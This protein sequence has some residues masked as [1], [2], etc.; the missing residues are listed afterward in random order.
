MFT[1][2]NALR[3]ATHPKVM[4]LTLDPTLT[5]S[6][7]IRNISIQAHKPLQLI[8][9]LTATG[10]GKQNETLLATYK[11][12]KR[13][14]LE[15]VSS[16]LLPLESST[17][18]NK[19]QVMQNAAFRTATGC[20]QDTNI[21]HLHDETLILPIHEHLQLHASQYKHKTQHPSHPL[22]K[23]TTYFNTPLSLTTAATQQ[24]FPH[25]PTQ[26]LQQT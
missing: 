25:N 15:Y 10:W 3:M 2:T 19:L 13:P 16:I 11:T 9:A 14:V 17:S 22:H 26:S 20:T 7:H 24:T 5:Y 4:G 18:I 8:K 21:Q 23:H 12:V 6:T 1:T